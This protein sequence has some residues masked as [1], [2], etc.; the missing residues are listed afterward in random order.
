MREK[1][2]FQVAGEPLLNGLFGVLKGA[3]AP[4]TPRDMGCCALSCTSRRQTGDVAVGRGIRRHAIFLSVALAHPRPR[5]VAAKVVKRREVHV[6]PL[7]AGPRYLPSTC[8]SVRRARFGSTKEH[9]ERR[10]PRRR[11]HAVGAP[12][13]DEPCA[14]PPLSSAGSVIAAPPFVLF[15]SKERRQDRPVPALRSHS[16]LRPPW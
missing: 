3:P 1:G 15:R 13:C 5:R 11:R 10:L 12:G 2:H 14:A 16:P 7:P 9:G 6:L 8:V 4:E